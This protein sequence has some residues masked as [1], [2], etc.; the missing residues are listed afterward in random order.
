MCS[1][2]DVP[3]RSPSVLCDVVAHRLGFHLDL[4]DVE[5]YRVADG[6]NAGE[7]A[8]IVDDGEMAEPAARP[9]P[10][11]LVAGVGFEYYCQMIQEAVAELKGEAVE[12]F[13][14]PPVDIPTAAFIPDSYIDDDGLRIAFYK[15]IT[16]VK[17]ASHL[18][19]VQ[20]E[21]EDRF[22][23][24]PKPVWAMLRLL[25]LRLKMK[26]YFSSFAISSMMAFSF[27]TSGS[28]RFSHS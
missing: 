8:G 9:H 5:L 11:Q 15:K 22:G 2:D 4:A 10:H 17:N 16:A 6:N 18:S 14:L 19:A 28:R 1:D 20:E 24:P 23:D 25:G 21:L 13:V 12:E 7:A 26:E 3:H 27:C